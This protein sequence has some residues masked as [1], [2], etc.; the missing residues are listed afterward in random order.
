MVE[1]KIRILIADDIKDTR[2]LIRRLLEM[3]E[4]FEVV[5]EA[6]NGLEVLQFVKQNEV[7]IVLMDINMPELNGLEATGQLTI[8][9][10]DIIVVIMSV[11]SESEY[12]KKAMLYGA[13]E[14]IIKPLNFELVAQ[15]LTETYSRHKKIKQVSAVSHKVFDTKI[16]S[17]FG[18]KG[19]TGKTFLA[20]NTAI[21]LSKEQKKK[22]LLIDTDLQFGDLGLSMGLKQDRTITDIVEEGAEHSYE[23][24]IPYLLHYSE[25]LDVIIS[26]HKAEHAEYIS[27]KAIDDLLKTV[28]GYY[29]IIICDLGVNYSDVTLAIMDASTQIHFVTSMELAAVQNAIQG[30]EVMKSL[31]YT[32]DKVKVIVN[33]SYRGSGMTVKDIEKAIKMKVHAEVEEQPKIVRHVMNIGDPGSLYTRH[34]HTKIVKQLN[35]VAN[36]IDS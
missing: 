5:G 6:E 24:L 27:K 18:T 30:I 9:H 16:I 13:K 4:Q 15:T 29:D 36:L 17:Y 21:F 32:S 28:N 20:M 33:K 25:N 11:Q 22:V 35:M 7:D 23:A 8:N 10:P 31:N 12:L 1:Q 2:Q 26:P 34:R 14:F 3:D 19:G